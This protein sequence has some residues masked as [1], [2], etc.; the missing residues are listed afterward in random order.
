MQCYNRGPNLDFQ[1]D[2]K[3]SYGIF[4]S[5]DMTYMVLCLHSLALYYTHT[6]IRLKEIWL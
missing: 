6:F 4:H 1:S 5:L 3:Y 2:L